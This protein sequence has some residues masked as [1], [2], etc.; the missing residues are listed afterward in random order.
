MKQSTTKNK[1][2]TK[3]KLLDAVG[4]IVSVHGFRK[5]GINEV[6]RQ[7]GVSKML[8]YRY[9]IDLDGLL[10]A[11]A[12]DM[13][14]WI[15]IDKFLPENIKEYKHAEMRQLTAEVLIGQLKDLQAKPELQELI[16][17]GL[18]EKNTLTNAIAKEFEEKVSEL[19]DGFQARIV[20]NGFDMRALMAIMIS[21]IYYLVLTSGPGAVFNGI[22]LDTKQGWNRIEAAIVQMVA[23]IFEQFTIK[24]K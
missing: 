21:G 20:S 11:Y 3:Q 13:N 14:Y 9:F 2:A 22:H 24:D 5:V 17:W 12:E 10:K 16:R 15:N 6:A 1:E 4:N 23:C 8:I 7:A 19:M 18:I